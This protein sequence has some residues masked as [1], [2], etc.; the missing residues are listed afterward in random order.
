MFL[1]PLYVLLIGQQG[2]AVSS[3]KDNRSSNGSILC[4]AVTWLEPWHGLS[5][6]SQDSM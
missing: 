1:H 2:Q 6:E 5:R 3:V 4:H